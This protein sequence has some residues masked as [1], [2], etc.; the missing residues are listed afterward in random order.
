MND[1]FQ[2]VYLPNAVEAPELNPSFT[3]VLKSAFNLENDV[4]NLLDFMSKPTFEPD[5]NFKFQ[6]AFKAQQLPMEWMPL[7]SR[8]TSQPEFDFLVGKV[9]QEYKDKAVLAA[10][11]WGGTV[12]AIGAGVL[13]PTMFIPF[14]GQARGAKGFAQMLALAAAGAGA[15]NGALFLNQQ[16]QT[17]GELYAGIAMDTLLMGMMGGAWMGLT[18]RFREELASD[19]LFNQKKIQV[20]QGPLDVPSNESFSVR[21]EA[22]AASEIKREVREL[23]IRNRDEV[24]EM[25]DE[26]GVGNTYVPLKERALQIGDVKRVQAKSLEEQMANGKSF[27]EVPVAQGVVARFVKVPAGS[28][29]KW[30]Q[31]G[32]Y[33]I[34]LRAEDGT[35]IS[36]PQSAVDSFSKAGSTQIYKEAELKQAIAD[37]KLDDQFYEMLEAAEDNGMVRSPDEGTISTSST[38]A[39]NPVGAQVARTRN[40][41]GAKPAPNRIAQAAMNT[42]GRLSPSYRMLTQRFF[43]SLRDGIA[44]LDMSGIQQAGLDR[45]EGSARSGTVIERIRGYDYYIVKFAKDLDKN[46]Y[47][48]IHGTDQGFDFGSPAVTQIKSMMG[49]MPGGKMN[50]NQYKEAVFD[51]LNTGEVPSDIA[52]SVTAFK[53]FFEN[54]TA[55]QR[56][57]LAEMKAEGMEVEP[58]FKELLSDELGE[59]IE[60]YAHHIFSKQKLMEN[61]T[62]FIDDF[63]G[64]N[65][66]QL[67]ESFTKARQRYKKKQAKLEF[68]RTVAEMDEAAISQRLDEVEAELEF[69]EE[70]PEMQSFRQERLDINRQ[71]REEGWSKEQL[72]A[73]LKDLQDNIPPQLRELQ[74]DRKQLMQVA[75]V[76]RNYGGDS[77]EKTAKL[78]ADIDK[79]DELIA[80]MFR[81]ELPGI[82]R[83]D[84]SVEKVQAQGDK[85]LKQVND[86]LKK[87]VTALGK[88]QAQMTKLLGSKRGNTASRAKV[89]EQI[90]AA[91]LKY[92]D[93][94]LRLGEVEGQ[95]VA[96][97]Q[98][99]SE[100]QLIRE[101]VISDAVR[102]VRKRAATVEDLEDRL[103]A[104]AKKLLTPEE[105]A[106]MKAQVE[107][108]AMQLEGKFRMD[109][110][111]KGE[112]SGDPVE[113]DAPDFKEHAREMAQMLHQKLMN[114]EVELSPAYRAVRQDARGPELLRVMKIPYEIKNKWLEKDVEIVTRAYDRAM[115]PDL[116][117]WRAFDGSVNATSLLGEMQDEVLAQINLISSSKYVKLPKGWTDKAA[118]FSDRVKKVLTELGEADEIYLEPG[119]YSNEAK[120]GFIELTPELRN[121]LNQSVQ[122]ALKASKRDLDVAIM[123][124][125][126]TRAVPQD[127]GSILWRTGRFAKNL[128]VTTLMG[129]VLTSSVSDVARPIWRHG[130]KKTFN[131]G[132][133]PF[134]NG[135]TQEGKKYRIMAKEI[136]ARCIL[137]LEP[138]LHGRSQGVFD[139]A[140]DSIGQTK[141]EQGMTFLA[142]KTGLV[143]MYDYW[144]AG[145]KS[146]AG[147]VAHATMAE[148][149]PAVAK[150]W[151]DGVE[152]TGD[153]LQMRTYLR[154]MGLS[155]LN[156]NRISVQMERPGGV[157]NFSNGGVL[158]NLD[159][160]D[161]MAAY[162]AYQAA[163]LKEVN[164]LI[165]TPGLERPNWTDENMAY[166]LVAQFKSF[167]FSSTSRMAMSGL[168]GNDPYLMQGVAFSIAFGALSYYTYALTAG[169][170]TLEEANKMEVDN[171]IWQAVTRS[172]ILGAVSLAADAAMEVPAV[173][174][175]EPT[176]FTKPSG[177]LGEFLG[178]TYS[179]AEKMANVVMQINSDDPEQQA[180]NLRAIR[181]VFIP[182][183]NHFLWRQ[184][185]DRAGE[186]MIGG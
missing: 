96:L 129:G 110:S 130:I 21:L 87:L 25:L 101:D 30:F 78:K 128:N 160:W 4:V 134:I 120:P 177:L 157:E 97:D 116:E 58:L 44:K 127:P 59:G 150:A 50:W 126:A 165:V 64:Y 159:A 172:G 57:Y 46:Y 15:Q 72:K 133:A 105:R 48:Y 56:Q 17:E 106:R 22:P 80:D 37:G 186:A 153:L 85:A 145:M 179:Q 108:E 103:E 131:K 170:K 147:N 89:A 135:F 33:S 2:N 180:R 20:P 1:L 81:K 112:R 158:P 60:G 73:T 28:G 74:A 24:Q 52:D 98:R 117:I 35:E 99:L 95:N 63:A 162:Q 69:L 13:S 41:L 86:K 184:A 122:D 19:I 118:K 124:L 175:E 9:Q 71:A 93:M 149:V 104:T 61:F 114:T 42:L 26:A 14:A 84:L 32:E 121:Q 18:G 45:M 140:E 36:I 111:A 161:D 38:D 76:L 137:N 53:E 40:T 168:Q 185:L 82:E 102:L 27:L 173:S 169:G 141:L 90:E 43:P 154:N 67:V 68:E 16:T 66:K 39:T 178:V 176:I 166:S 62:D 79:A 148:Y 113:T 77:V 119:N 3:Q 109:W 47:R 174:G 171:W 65:E 10:G 7:L 107:D 125:R 151:R 23:G 100:L 75:K 132:W 31:G 139:L 146:I 181:Q 51:S 94:L 29:G 144:T 91:K 54:Y 155:D 12:A 156:I 8:A 34:S 5:T 167:T 123:R 143:A 6:E 183:Q 88:R 152:P 164:E 182:Y 163:I 115:A 49:R 11:G 83:V 142:N 70:I 92:D 138:M 55:R 136:N